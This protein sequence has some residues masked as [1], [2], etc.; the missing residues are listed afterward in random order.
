MIT[1]PHAKPNTN[2]K[3]QLFYDFSLFKGSIDILLAE[4]PKTT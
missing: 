1:D 3:R 4:K 2:H